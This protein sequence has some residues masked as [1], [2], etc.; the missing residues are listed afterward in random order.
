MRQAEL[1]FAGPSEAPI[2]TAEEVEWLV[3]IL[4]GRGWQTAQKIEALAGGTKNDRKI[5]AIARAAGHGIVSYPG[6]P[7]YKLWS[8]CT[9]DEIGHCLAAIQS[10]I[11]DMT[12]RRAHYERAY[13]AKYRGLS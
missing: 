9:I 4:K 13:H 1:T 10:Q 8:E 6:S 2:A 5:R 7:G 11:T 12:V 3:S